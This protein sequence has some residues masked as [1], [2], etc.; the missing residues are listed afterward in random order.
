MC[1]SYTVLQV[2]CNYMHLHICDIPPYPLMIGQILE[3]PQCCLS[4]RCF[5]HHQT[6]QSLNVPFS[7]YLLFLSRDITLSSEILK[8]FTEYNHKNMGT[9][10][11]RNEIETKRS[12]TKPSETKSNETKRNETKWIFSKTKCNEK[13]W[14]I[15]YGMKTKRVYNIL[16]IQI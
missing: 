9:C 14:K 6:T 1:L 15:Q 5:S 3:S 8:I 16:I 4:V 13:K 11:V 7:A 10:K 12:E 2:C